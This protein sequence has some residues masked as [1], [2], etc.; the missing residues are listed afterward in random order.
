MSRMDVTGFVVIK[1][2]LLKPT[3][4]ADKHCTASTHLDVKELQATYG[5]G[6]YRCQ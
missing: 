3:N 5:R 2:S 4:K 6:Q 1:K